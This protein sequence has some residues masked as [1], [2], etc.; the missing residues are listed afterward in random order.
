[1]KTKVTVAMFL[2]TAVFASAAFAAPGGPG[3][4]AFDKSNVPGWT[5]MTPDERTEHQNKMHSF[6]TYDECKAYQQEH[7]A[8]MQ[9]RAK[10]KGVTLPTPRANACDRMKARGFLK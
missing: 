6:K 3:R 7:H 9:Q 8:L 10:E 4:F 1:M 2:S 5:L